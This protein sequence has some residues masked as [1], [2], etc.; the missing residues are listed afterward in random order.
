[1][2]PQ[3]TLIKDGQVRFWA[4]IND[5]HSLLRNVNIEYEDFLIQASHAR[6]VRPKAKRGVFFRSSMMGRSIGVAQLQSEYLD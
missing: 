6:S 4:F 2:P 3:R 1:M 5:H